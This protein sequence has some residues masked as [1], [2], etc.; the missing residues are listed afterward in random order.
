M[1]ELG[2]RQ[3]E[4]LATLVFEPVVMAAVRELSAVVRE[5]ERHNCIERDRHIGLFGFSAGGAAALYVLAEAAVPVDAAVTFNASTGY[6]S[7]SNEW[8]AS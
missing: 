5:L 4:D 1:Q 2:R 6:T 3:G 8:S 7:V